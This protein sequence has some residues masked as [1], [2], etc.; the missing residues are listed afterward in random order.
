MDSLKVLTVSGTDVE[1]I[2]AIIADKAVS[3]RRL[4]QDSPLEAERVC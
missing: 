4:P 1:P 2:R 3:Q